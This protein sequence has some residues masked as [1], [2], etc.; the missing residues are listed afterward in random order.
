MNKRIEPLAHNPIAAIR[1]F[2]AQLIAIRRDL[3]AHPELRFEEVRTAAIVTKELEQLGIEVHTGIGKTGV[4]GVI[5]GKHKRGTRL[6]ARTIGLRAD[7]DALPI[8]KENDVA[9]RSSVPHHMHACGHDG[10]T[11]MLRGA[12]RYLAATRNFD[13]TVHLIFQPGV[14]GCA[15]AKAM[16]ED[17][18]FTRFPCD[19]V[20]AMHNSGRACRP[21]R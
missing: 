3:H 20:Y 9:H 5:H 1:R 4:V 21:A 8:A 15:G 2:H 13:G 16:I 10:R 7:M 14:E 6:S 17:D 12:A 18:L 11:T 19:A